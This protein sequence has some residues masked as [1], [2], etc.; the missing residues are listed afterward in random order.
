[1][2]FSVLFSFTEYL[3][4]KGICFIL[5]LIAWKLECRYLSTVVCVKEED[6]VSGVTCIPVCAEVIHYLLN[7]TSKHLEHQSNA[8]DKVKS[9]I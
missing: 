9:R 4:V 8:A 6:A 7:T 3:I 1:M 2:C 5:T